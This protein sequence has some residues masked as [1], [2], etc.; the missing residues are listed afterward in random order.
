[1]SLAVASVG[2]YAPASDRAVG[3]TG[4]EVRRSVD[5]ALNSPER[6]VEAL[7]RMTRALLRGQEEEGT[8]V[9]E[10]PFSRACDILAVL[11]SDVPLPEIVVESE[12]EIGLDWHADNRHVLS[13]TLDSSSYVGYAALLGHESVHGR[14]PFSGSLPKTIAEL[15]SRVHPSRRLF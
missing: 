15:L 12:N 2:L 6:W 11:P 10:K 13:L 14:V 7:T 1:M 5:R 3:A 4:Q 9:T 8:S